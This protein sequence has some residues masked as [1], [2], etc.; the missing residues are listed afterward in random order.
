MKA[1]YDIQLMV[2]VAKMYYLEGLTQEKIA[3]QLGISR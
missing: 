2:Q 3:Q 1:R